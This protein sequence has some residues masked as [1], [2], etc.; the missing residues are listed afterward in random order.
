MLQ[1]YYVNSWL[2]ETHA[3]CSIYFPSNYWLEIGLYWKLDMWQEFISTITIPY[4]YDTKARNTG[5]TN[6]IMSHV[7]TVVQC[8]E[9][10]AK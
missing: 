6:L 3:L 9:I 5:K 4:T 2:P 7:F 10:T 1:E 8:S